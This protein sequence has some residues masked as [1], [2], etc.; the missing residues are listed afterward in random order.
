KRITPI[1]AITIAITN[2]FVTSERIVMSTDDACAPRPAP[3]TAPPPPAPVTEFRRPVIRD[4]ADASAQ[5]CASPAERTV[6]APAG[7]VTACC[8]TVPAP[9]ANLRAYCVCHCGEK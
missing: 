2:R 8:Q 3:P 6:F 4:D 9:A 7:I 5:F 1:P